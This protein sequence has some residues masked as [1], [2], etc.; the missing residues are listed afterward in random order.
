MRGELL[1]MTT[2]TAELPTFTLTGDNSRT[3]S[4]GRR[5][6]FAISCGIIFGIA[7]GVRLLYWQDNQVQIVQGAGWF[8]DLLKPYRVEA[9]RLLKD[10]SILFPNTPSDQSDA[11]M[12]VHPPGYSLLIATLYGGGEPDDSYRML[13]LTQVLCDA[14]AA[15]VIFLIAAEL[16]PTAL[17]AIS[18]ILVAI[19]PHFAFNS[20]RL[21]PDTIA[22][23]PI[24]LA[25]Y[26]IIGATKSRPLAKLILAGA[27]I[28]LSCWFRG[29]A[30]LLAPWLAVLLAVLFKPG[31]RLRYSAA[32]VAATLIV[33]AP[34]TVRNW[35]VYHRFI[36]LS[37]PTGINL[38]QGIAEYDRQGSFGMPLQD[39]D[40]QADEAK[41]YGRPDYGDDLWVP[42]GI[43]RDHYRL[44]RGVAVIRSNPGWFLNSMAHR[45][46]F[47]LSYNDSQ[48]HD[49]PFNTAM[50]PILSREPT[51]GHALEQAAEAQ[52]IWSS[53]PSELLSG[54]TVLSPA[55]KV[56]IDAEGK[57]LR[58]EGDGSEFGHQF[59]SSGVA[60]RKN[61]D[62][63]LTLAARPES[64]SMSVSITT[65]DRRAGL[66]STRIAV[67]KQ[68]KGRR[69]RE[70]EEILNL[71]VAGEQEFTLIR[72]AFATG[73]RD[74]V[75]LVISNDG[76]SPAPPVA[77]LSR[78]AISEY[79]PTPY[80]WSRYPRATI[81]WFQKNLFTTAHMIPL[82]VFGIGILIMF[83]H[84]KA[85]LILLAVP[86]YYLCTHAAFSTEYR[87]ILA[88]HYFLFIISAATIYSV[89]P[90]MR[91]AFTMIVSVRY[92]KS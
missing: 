9:E 89:G 44:S 16:L 92:R 84:G 21:S 47:M 77:A 74:E 86:V 13:R 73:N 18:A 72:L 7:L 62:Y 15:A 17:A 35:A 40:A 83:N 56:S 60:V 8:S 48:A 49:W 19:S 66:A 14:A 55:A 36:L 1:R 4:G 70:I 46:A 28:G 58:V 39:R 53:L 57:T 50:A 43:E 29:N 79:G 82:I 23:L 88:I 22:V 3:I 20:L 31:K 11:R 37:L 25:I 2:S 52:E 59:A 81:R 33:I 75:R 64:G 80:L 76:A 30:L 69:Q 34:I 6:L 41:R 27:L 5:V 90:A 45:A 71:G 78:A 32:L 65:T 61:T 54:G 12:L 42:D 91:L 26:F 85:L 24:L 38:I 10:G 87:Y 68:A 51:F 63:V 67:K